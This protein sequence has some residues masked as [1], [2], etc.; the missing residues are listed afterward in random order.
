MVE[1]TE[2]QIRRTEDA[3]NDLDFGTG[4]DM[5]VRLKKNDGTYG[6]IAL[7]NALAHKYLVIDTDGNEELFRYSEDLTAAGWVLD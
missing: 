5:K 3:F 4:L 7:D 6:Y 2:K 1:W